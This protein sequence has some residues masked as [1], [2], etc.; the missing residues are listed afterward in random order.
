MLISAR[1]PNAG[2]YTPGSTEKQLHGITYSYTG[3]ANDI[4]CDTDFPVTNADLA[5]EADLLV[6]EATFLAGQEEPANA[7]GHSTARQAGEIAAR[8]GAR[9]LALVHE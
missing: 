8:A 9:R 7:A 2:R 4:F 1:T 6:H 5:R 3:H